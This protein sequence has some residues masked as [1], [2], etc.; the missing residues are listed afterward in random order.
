[1]LEEGYKYWFADHKQVR[2]PFPVAIQEELKNLTSKRFHE[3]LDT[4]GE[5]EAAD[6]PDNQMIEMFEMFLF[7]TGISLCDD[8]D[9]QITITYPFMPRRGDEVDDVKN[10][11]SEVIRRDILEKNEGERQLQLILKRKS[12][13]GSWQT[14]FDLPA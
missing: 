7:N 11:P 1:M 10:G 13:G 14:E 6:M 2:S 8:P 4:L 3:W 5:A 12:D 9:Q